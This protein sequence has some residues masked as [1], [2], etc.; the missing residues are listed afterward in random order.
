MTSIK[1]SNLRGLLF[2]FFCVL[3]FH[4]IREIPPAGSRRIGVERAPWYIECGIGIKECHIA[5]LRWGDTFHPDLRQVPAMQE[6]AIANG[7]YTLRNNDRHQ[8][9][10]L[11][12]CQVTDLLQSGRKHY[13][14]QSAALI[15][16]TIAQRFHIVW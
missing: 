9:V 2:L 11:R 4:N 15:E 12:E 7:A 5:A 8:V 6:R 16:S 1:K 3:Y 14:R 10:T 13:R